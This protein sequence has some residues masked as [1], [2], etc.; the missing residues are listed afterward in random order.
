MLKRAL[1]VRHGDALVDREA[2]DLMKDGRVRGVELVGAEDTP[3][4]D[5]V[6]G[7]VALEHGAE[8]NGGRLRPHDDATVLAAHEERV[9][10][11][12]R[13]VV[14]RDVE[15]IEVEPLGFSLGP[16]GHLVAHRRE[17]LGHT[18]HESAEG[19]PCP[20][21]RAPGRHRD[22]H[23]F[24]DEDMRVALRLECSQA[25]LEGLADRLTGTPHTLSRF[26]LG[27]RRERPDLAIG[28]RERR[29]IARVSQAHRLE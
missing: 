7:Q 5:D 25:R 15:R 16:L 4:R 9:L 3:G 29:P 11:R 24:L 22:I 2:L 19:V 21:N 26:G 12:A 13:R 8:L 27:S 28:E 20:E 23:G 14:G 1:E 18:L 17:Y 10:H 6:D